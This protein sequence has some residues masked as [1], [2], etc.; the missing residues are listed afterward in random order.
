MLLAEQ[1]AIVTGGARGIGRATAR[2][3]AQE[4]AAVVIADVNAAGAQDAAAEL[5][6][7]GQRALAV[8]T[9]VAEPAQVEAMV[10]RTMETFGRIDILVNNAGTAALTP[11]LETTPEVWDR[12]LK[13]HL[14]GTFFCTQAAAR[15]MVT[16]RYGRIVN[17]SSVSALV[18]SVGRAAYGAAKGGL[19]ALTRV[20]A[21]ELAPYGIRVNAV[22]PGAVETE[23]T[24]AAWT[25]A[26][27]EGYERLTPVPRLG[28]PHDIAHAIAFLCL[29]ASDYI[30]GQ[31]LV[32]DGGFAVAG[33]RR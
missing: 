25:P 16:R 15:H 18:G 29:P 4:G 20:L 27:R 32:V 28:Q 22:A 3:L 10:Q 1:V 26:D 14:Y 30:T 19:I 33:I 2:R 5:V 23:L 13:V 9:D 24:R 6:A 8:P 31:V 17:V 12:T 7:L 21:V 11:L